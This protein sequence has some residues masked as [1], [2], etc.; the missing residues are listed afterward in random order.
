MDAVA[1]IE[2]LD[3]G[4]CLRLIATKSI[5]RVG[6]TVGALPTVLPVNFRLIGERL[7]FRT[8]CDE[9]VQTATTAAVIAFEVD[10]FDEDTQEGWTVVITGMAEPVVHVD[11]ERRLESIGI[12]NWAPVPLPRIVA[13][14]TDVV[15][16]QWLRR[17]TD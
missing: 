9:R 12:P 11:V 13:M 6:L 3:R 5:G 2:T 10:H 8:S 7:F 14:S 1:T 4:E 16:G 17:V 15:T